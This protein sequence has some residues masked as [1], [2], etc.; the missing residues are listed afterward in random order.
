LLLFFSGGAGV[1]VVG[2]KCTVAKAS[3]RAARV[4]PALPPPPMPAQSKSQSRGYSA[5]SSAPRCGAPRALVG[6]AS[7]LPTARPSRAPKPPAQASDTA[8]TAPRSPSSRMAGPPLLMALRR[9][10]SLFNNKRLCGAGVNSDGGWQMAGLGPYRHGH[11]P[12]SCAH[13]VA[14]SARAP[15]S[16]SGSGVDFF[17]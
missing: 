6:W 13:R 8:S 17:F 4:G 2:P 12:I 10:D 14:P 3:S 11:L 5:R 7:G 15:G 16:C 9:L 1:P